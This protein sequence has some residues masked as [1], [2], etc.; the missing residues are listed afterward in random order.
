[1]VG[2]FALQRRVVGKRDAD[3]DAGLRPG[4]AARN[5]PGTLHRVPG[6]LQQDPLLR[7]DAPGLARR[8]TEEASV[9][10]VDVGDK[11]ALARIHLAGAG[12]IGMEIA[13]D[14]PALLW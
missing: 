8:D 5:D 4:K 11:P 2:V 12:R 14:V 3:K 7:V 10:L 1:M 9:E 6:Q 13:G